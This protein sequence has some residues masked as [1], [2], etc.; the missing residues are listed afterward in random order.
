MMRNL[1]TYFVLCAYDGGPGGVTSLEMR[2]TFTGY[3][4]T[5]C[6]DPV[7]ARNSI[8]QGCWCVRARTY[9]RLVQTMRGRQDL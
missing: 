9:G 7:L 6:L 3:V 8:A 2:V 1:R 5:G 4:L